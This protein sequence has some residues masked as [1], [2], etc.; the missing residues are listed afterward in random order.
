MQPLVPMRR[1]AGVVAPLL[2]GGLRRTLARAGHLGQRLVA[3]AHAL[4]RLRRGGLRWAAKEAI[5]KAIGRM[6]R[7]SPR[8]FRQ[9]DRSRRLEHLRHYMLAAPETDFGEQRAKLLH[10]SHRV[11]D[12]LVNRVP[13]FREMARLERALGRELIAATYALR[14][15]RWAG[16]DTYGDLPFVRAT[17]QAQGFDR[18]AATA[19]AMF[20]PEQERDARCLEVMQDAFERN[21]RKRDLPL[22]VL[23]D[24][25]GPAPRRVA[26]IVSLYNA[27]GKLPTLLACLAQQSLAARGEARG[28]AGGQQLP[29]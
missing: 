8:T 27:A 2:P 10:L 12:H 15:M 19:E 11:T 4:Y 3:S 17:L 5:R 29:H 26:V 1:I 22:A 13:L 28:G 6:S 20:G 9:I 7:F 25:R 24:R 18:E 21:R 14:V 16:R 23:D